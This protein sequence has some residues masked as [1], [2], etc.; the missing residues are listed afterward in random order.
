MSKTLD[1]V[2]KLLAKAENAGTPEEAATFMA[3]AQEMASLN[4]I[5]LA[6]ARMHQA[7]KERAA[8]PEER[9]IQC[10]PFTRRHNRKFFIELGMAICD[11]NDVEYLIS[12]R[13]YA[14]HCVGFPED[15]DVV[16]ALYTHLSVQMVAECDEALARG[17]HRATRRVPVTNRVEIPW[18]N[19]EWGEWNG[20]QYYDDNP[21]D[22]VFVRRRQD[23]P[24]SEFEERER[25]T[26]EAAR[27]EY[28]EAVKT[29][30]RIYSQRTRGDGG[31]RRAVPPPSF[32][33]VPVLDSAGNS[34]YEEKEISVVDGR[35]FRSHFYG[36]FVPRMRGRLWAT[37]KAAERARGVDEVTS[38]TALAVR[39]KKEVVDAAHEAQRAKVL[40]IGSYQGSDA[41]PRKSDW[42]GQGRRAGTK[43]AD[44]VAIGE[45]RAVK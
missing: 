40:H 32:E 35:V 27:A 22:D 37:R 20:K 15:L 13:E 8:E 25:R 11:V 19:R 14:L 26:I 2:S 42:S 23:E 36:A 45:G 12:G 16:E 10:N 1:R 33:D 3:K 43:A 24:L 21:D 7:K 9:R 28:L 30:E 31:F 38:E 44:T 5:D 4:N 6:V 17:D 29:G 39:D 34:Q 41:Q 18:E